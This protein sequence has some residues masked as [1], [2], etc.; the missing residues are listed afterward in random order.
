M[1]PTPEEPPNGGPNEDDAAPGGWIDPDDRLWRHPSEVAGGPVSG[2]PSGP[3]G[4]PLAGT[5]TPARDARR[6][7]I[8]VLVA[9]AAVVAAVV[10]TGIL[11]LPDSSPPAPTSLKD[12][13]A[14]APLTTMAGSATALPVVATAAGHAMV[15]LRAETTR[16]TVD[17]VGVAEAEGG[18][19]VTLA[20]DLSGL[21]S[22]AMVGPGGQLLPAR[23]KG[24]DQKSDIALVQVPDDLPVAPFNDDVTLANGSADL[25]L[26][27]AGVTGTAATLRS[28]PGSVTGIGGAIA[29]GPAAGMPGITSTAVGVPVAAGDLLL[30]S[31]GAVLGIYYDGGSAGASTGPTF[32]PTELVLGVADDLRSSGRVTQGW[33]G[34]KGSDG[35][36]G[37]A[38]VATVAPGSPAAGHLASGD[39]IAAVDSV[40]IRTM[41]DL[42]GRLYVL[43]PSTRV[44]LGVDH[45][46]RSGVVDVTLSASP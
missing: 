7:K 6:T 2:P 19:V 38:A 3:V 16:G 18:L 36:Q 35:G 21:R 31:S 32:L 22:L 45:G 13:V 29:S 11:L 26:S 10:W 30:D 4:G 14:D 15:Q 44:S 46:T 27:V 17:L 24:V 28:T 42:R 39:V 34:I 41:A 43:P 8:M 37:G 5:A 1:T 12:T 33:L 25:T 23:L 40:P 9:A 20:A